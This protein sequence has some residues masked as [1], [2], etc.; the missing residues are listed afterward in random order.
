MALGV[1]PNWGQVLQEPNIA[2]DEG[3]AARQRELWMQRQGTMSAARQAELDQL[4]K[5]LAGGR[6]QKMA[7]LAAADA[8][9][10]A[11]A[12]ARG[13]G[14]GGGGKGAGGTG[15]FVP[16]P[17]DQPAP[18]LDQYL[19]SIPSG[20]PPTYGG[21]ITAPKPYVS[22]PYTALTKPVA[23]PYAAPSFSS[24][25]QSVAHPPG[26]RTPQSWVQPPPTHYSTRLS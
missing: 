16:L 7:E 19:A 14:G 1:G 23:N 8:A 22:D 24:R 5:A 3:G 10:A 21:S 9:A 4:T 11:K 2:I 18:W 25:A 20:P 26:A 12:A 15:M 17:T 6:D 13:G